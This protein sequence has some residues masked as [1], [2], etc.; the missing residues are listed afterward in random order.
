MKIIKKRTLKIASNASNGAFQWAGFQWTLL[1]GAVLLSFQFVGNLQA[2]EAPEIVSQKGWFV[3]VNPLIFGANKIE[4]KTT[5]VSTGGGEVTVGDLTAD[6]RNL[7]YRRL[8]DSQNI[9]RDLCAGTLPMDTM[10]A[11]EIFYLAS[12]RIDATDLALGNGGVFEAVRFWKNGKK[13]LFSRDVGDLVDTELKNVSPIADDECEKDFTGLLLED[14]ASTGGSSETSTGK[15]LAGNGLQVGYR[16]GDYRYSLSNF[17]WA[18]GADKL[19]SQVLLL[20]YFIAKG[21][22]AGIGVA[23]VK[24]DSSAGLHSQRANVYSLSYHYPIWKN[25]FVEASY[26]LISADISVQ[27]EELKVFEEVN[28]TDTREIGFYV[29]QSTSTGNPIFALNWTEVGTLRD[30]RVTV[31][32]TQTRAATTRATTKSVK[33]KNP[34]AFRINFIWRFF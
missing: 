1:L 7:E 26:M 15:A 12:D 20:E 31:T 17:S 11:L 22:S 33:I 3:G 13:Q 5:V 14:Q 21:F 8:E 9:A 18:A 6:G 34:A 27:K 32:R 30:N 23:N 2:Q 29:N 4:T 25:L 28:Q 24:L 10:D 19:D 16:D